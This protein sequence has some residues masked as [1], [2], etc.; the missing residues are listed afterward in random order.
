M[1]NET[2][3]DFSNAAKIMGCKLL[4]EKFDIAMQLIKR[5]IIFATSLY[6]E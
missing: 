5:D 2:L 1:V 3:R 6:F 4:S